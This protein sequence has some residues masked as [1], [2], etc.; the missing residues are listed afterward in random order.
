ME[1]SSIP[2]LCHPKPLCL[3]PQLRTNFFESWCFFSNPWEC[4]GRWRIPGGPQS[5]ST[6][7]MTYNETQ[8][9]LSTQRLD[10]MWVAFLAAIP[11]TSIGLCSKI[12]F[13]ADQPT[14]KAD[15]LCTI[16]PHGHYGSFG[17]WQRRPTQRA[18]HGLQWGG[19]AKL[20]AL[21][22]KPTKETQFFW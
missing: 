8:I 10:P 21:N 16:S 19:F 5:S 11:S 12:R 3:C 15:G 18:E 2:A 20:R 17:R 6:V 1:H 14:T 7:D 22:G 9:I 4:I 13:F